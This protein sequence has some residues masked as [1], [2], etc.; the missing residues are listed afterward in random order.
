MNGYIC[1]LAQEVSHVALD[2]LSRGPWWEQYYSSVDARKHR[3]A[4]EEVFNLL[5]LK[6][7][8]FSNVS[9][10]VYKPF[11]NSVMGEHLRTLSSISKK[12]S[13]IEVSFY[14]FLGDSFTL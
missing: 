4:T 8:T 3:G 7:C 14:K 10:F 5:L 12:R 6:K 11:P 1:V 13:L 9:E 2:Y